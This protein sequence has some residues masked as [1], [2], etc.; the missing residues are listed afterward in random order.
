MIIYHWVFSNHHRR[1]IYLV[2]ASP[3]LV[4]HNTIMQR[5]PNLMHLL[6]FACGIMDLIPLIACS[7]TALIPLEVKWCAAEGS[8]ESG[9]R[10][11]CNY[12]FQKILQ[13]LYHD[14]IIGMPLIMAHVHIVSIYNNKDVI[15]MSNCKNQMN[16]ISTCNNKDCNFMSNCKNQ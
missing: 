12:G 5:H 4:I 3:R 1:I 15:F 16:L 10:E 7:T 6:I 13:L 14:Q 8:V 2:S 11:G 9:I